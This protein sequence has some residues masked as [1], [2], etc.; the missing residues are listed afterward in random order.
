MSIYI[1]DTLEQ[2]AN[3]PIVFCD[4]ITKQYN[5]NGV[6]FELNCTVPFGFFHKYLA[7]RLQFENMSWY[8]TKVT[9]LNYN[10]FKELLNIAETFNIKNEKFKKN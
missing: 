4:N 10:R 9:S 3:N 1:E 5:K 6:F 8:F 7:L 2:L